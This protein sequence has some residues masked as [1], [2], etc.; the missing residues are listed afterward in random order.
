MAV[1]QTT[2]NTLREKSLAARTCLSYPLSSHVHATLPQTTAEKLPR[3]R[4]MIERAPQVNTETPKHESQRMQCQL[5]RVSRTGM[6]RA[7]LDFAPDARGAQVTPRLLASRC[8][9]QRELTSNALPTKNIT[10]E[11][12]RGGGGF[13]R[14]VTCGPHMSQL[15]TV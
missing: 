1:R 13:A 6:E 14:K 12:G 5:R 15:P 2:T 9:L 7:V 3:V 8:S 4:A 11:V 10:R